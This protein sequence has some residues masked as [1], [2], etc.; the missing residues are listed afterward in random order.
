MKDLIRSGRHLV[1][2]GYCMYGSYC[3]MILVSE[4][5][6]RGKFSRGHQGLKFPLRPVRSQSVGNGVNGFTLDPAIG[7]F[8]MTHPNVS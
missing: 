3:E 4:L 6:I 1:A 5:R 8:I 2:A 7:E